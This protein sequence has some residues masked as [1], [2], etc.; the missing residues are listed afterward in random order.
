MTQL[1]L[2]EDQRSPARFVAETA[3]AYWKNSKAKIV[4]AIMAGLSLDDITKLVRKEYS[5]YGFSGY[6][7]SGEDYDGYDLTESRIWIHTKNEMRKYEISWKAF[8]K[9][10]V[11]MVKTGEYKE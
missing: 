5:P 9:E 1:S 2:F 8:T 7:G 6:Y 11:E 3:T 10:I 4:N